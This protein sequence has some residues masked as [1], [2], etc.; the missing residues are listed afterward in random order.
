MFLKLEKKII[1][2]CQFLKLK[3]SIKYLLWL[4]HKL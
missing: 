4:G 1:K 3:N 2:N